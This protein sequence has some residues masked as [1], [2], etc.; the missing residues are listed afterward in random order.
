MWMNID[1]SLHKL[2]SSKNA[3]FKLP[4]VNKDAEDL[5]T[6][7]IDIP[8]PETSVKPTRNEQ[9][10]SG[11]TQRARLKILSVVYYRDKYAAVKS[12]IGADAN[13][14]SIKPLN[15][16]IDNYIIVDVE[17][18]SIKFD[19]MKIYYVNKNDLKLLDV[20]RKDKYI[21][22]IEGIPVSVTLLPM[23]RNMDILPITIHST[24]NKSE[25][26]LYRYYSVIQRYPTSE[27]NTII[28]MPDKHINVNVE[29]PSELKDELDQANRPKF[30]EEEMVNEYKKMVSKLTYNLSITDVIRAKNINEVKAAD[31]IGYIIDVNDLRPGLHCIVICSQ[32]RN[33]FDVLVIPNNNYVLTEESLN[34]LKSFMYAEYLNYKTFYGKH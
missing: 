14:I 24:T 17:Y 7:P 16:I 9:P 20:N 18:I 19:P 8:K 13:V 6:E 32:K 5:T 11:Y 28:S 26:D 33:I 22:E 10:K 21:C 1:R 27:Y 31:S 23:H 2:L 3:A 30:T 12:Y 29:Y 34:S 15:Y 4:T 25:N